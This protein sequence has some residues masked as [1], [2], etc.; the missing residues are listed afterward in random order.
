V[1]LQGAAVFTFRVWLSGGKIEIT[2]NIGV[3]GSSPGTTPSM[4]RKS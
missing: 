1:F 3:C 4:P 2:N